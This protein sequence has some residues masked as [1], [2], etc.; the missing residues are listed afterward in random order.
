MNTFKSAALV[1]ILGLSGIAAAEPDVRVVVT[2][3]VERNDF[4]SGTYFGVPVGAPVTMTIDLDSTDYLDSPSLPGVT[5]GYRFYPNTFSLTI[6]NVTRSLRTSPVLPAYFVVR[7]DD[8]RADGFFISQGT[9]IDTEIPLDMIPNNYG[10]AFLRT[11]N[12]IPT[13]P[14]GPDPTLHSVNILDA[15]GSWGYDNLS[16]FNMNIQRGEGSTPLIMDY[17]TITISLIP[18]PCNPD[19]NQDGVAD[20]GDVDYLINVIAG[21]ENPSGI[22]PDFNQDGVPDQGDVDALINVVAGGPCP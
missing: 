1:A 2:G 7:N 5:R 14:P 6:G 11:F 18:P 16:V 4:I 12:S 20:Q 22:D 19:V 9:D 17:Q 13:N 21:G 8:P 10:I 3:V 15:L